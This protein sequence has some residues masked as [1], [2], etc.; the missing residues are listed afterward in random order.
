MSTPLSDGSC[1][2]LIYRDLE[3]D[4]RY[5]LKCDAVDCCREDNDGDTVEY[6]IP[7]V[8]PAIL[9]P[10][11]YRGQKTLD[12]FDGVSVTVDLYEWT[13]LVE[14]TTAYV[15]NGT[16]PNST[17]VLQKWD[18]EIDGLSYPNQY[19]NFTAVPESEAAAFK[20]SFKVPEICKGNNIPRCANAHRAGLL[21]AKSLRFVRAGRKTSQ[22]FRRPRSP[23]AGCGSVRSHHALFDVM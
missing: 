16:G 5:L 4:S 1:Q 7:N 22:K 3:E 17:A 8:H 6:Q 20:A 9:A 19:A 23:K 21:S 15:T 12:R 18:V 14:K 10:V 2:R 13:F 11:H